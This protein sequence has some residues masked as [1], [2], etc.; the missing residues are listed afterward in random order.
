MWF[1]TSTF[2]VW[3][4]NLAGASCIKSVHK[5]HNRT[6]TFSA[7]RFSQIS[8]TRQVNTQ[9]ALLS[10]HINCFRVA[11][12]LT[13]VTS[14][15]LQISVDTILRKDVNIKFAFSDRLTEISVSLS[16]QQLYRFSEQSAKSQRR[17]I[18]PRL[19]CVP[20]FKKQPQEVRKDTFAR[21][22]KENLWPTHWCL[23]ADRLLICK[24]HTHVFD[25]LAKQAYSLSLYLFL[26]LYVSFSLSV[27]TFSAFF[28]SHH[29][30]SNAEYKNICRLPLHD[31]VFWLR[32]ESNCPFSWVLLAFL[33]LPVSIV[34]QRKCKVAPFVR[35]YPE[36]NRFCT[37]TM[38][39]ARLGVL[40][41]QRGL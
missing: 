22:V 26:S 15:L 37:F 20:S 5:S 8:S 6:Q 30:R 28:F 40:V 32:S 11:F 19:L 2:C 10:K 18:V 35:S 21:I 29:L 4:H 7:I 17:R 41:F 39:D 14:F 38:A 16:I 33:Y 23:F 31:E 24:H 36:R 1:L 25:W 12:R 13:W 27:S 9:T 34:S 3:V